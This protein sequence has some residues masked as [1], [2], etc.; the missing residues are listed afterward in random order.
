MK[1][2][3]TF[4]AAAALACACGSS[5]SGNDMVVAATADLAMH[6]GPGS[7]D[8]AML[9]AAA[10]MARTTTMIDMAMAMTGGTIPDPGNAM[11][12]EADFNDVPGMSNHTPATAIPLGQESGPNVYAWVTN[13]TIMAGQTD[14]FVFASKNGGTFQLGTS[15]T[16]GICGTAN[17]S[18]VDLWTVAAGQM[19]LPPVA[20]W[21]PSAANPNCIPGSTPLVAGKTYLI[22]F[23]ATAN[24]AYS[25]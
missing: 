14:Y 20:E 15:P 6:S 25:V 7:G 4:F 19:Q 21:T 12:G 3:R 16:G 1:R 17:L 18:K 5:K 9:Q 13:N 10:D 24:G 2:S 22:G 8:M 11:P 23:T